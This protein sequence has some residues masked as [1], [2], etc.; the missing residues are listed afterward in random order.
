M[1]ILRTFLAARSRRREVQ[2]ILE[3][4]LIAERL[5]EIWRAEYIKGSHKN[6]ATW[7]QLRS[8]SVRS[9]DLQEDRQ[10]WLAVARRFLQAGRK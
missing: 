8:G 6:Q 1:R 9:I 7:A 10:G 2:Q 3:E 4:E 5:Y